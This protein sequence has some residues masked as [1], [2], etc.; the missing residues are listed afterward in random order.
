MQIQE[1]HILS[2]YL[3]L[4]EGLITNL[5]LELIEK[6]SQSVKA[7]LGESPSKMHQAFGAW[8]C[9]ETPETVINQI[10]EARNTNREL[11]SFS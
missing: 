5:K 6:L 2:Q 7:D 1:N 11:V 10:R 4:L 3:K 8:Q 9:D